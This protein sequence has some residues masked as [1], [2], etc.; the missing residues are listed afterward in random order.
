[1]ATMPE[2][3]VGYQAAEV[4]AGANAKG[5][6]KPAAAVLSGVGTVVLTIEDVGGSGGAVV[7]GAVPPWASEGA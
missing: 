7:P 2:E 5:A 1:M 4:V 3:F 6:G